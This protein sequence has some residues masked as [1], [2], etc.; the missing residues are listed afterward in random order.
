MGPTDATI[1]R[2]FLHSLR[3]QGGCLD[4]I[5]NESPHA[6][7]PNNFIQRP[8][9]HEKFLRRISLIAK[10]IHCSDVIEALGTLTETIECSTGDHES[11]SLPSSKR[12]IIFV[13]YE[14]RNNEKSESSNTN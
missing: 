5:Y 12:R 7:L 13:G 14:I 10:V 4:S 2:H 8:L 9:A 3:L 11:I 1:P 6:E